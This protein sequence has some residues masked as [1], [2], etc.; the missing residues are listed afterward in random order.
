MRKLLALCVIT[1]MMIAVSTAQARIYSIKPT[2]SFIKGIL[3]IHKYEG[4]WKDDGAPY[5]GGVQM[6]WDF[7]LTYGLKAVQA[8]GTANHWPIW[9]QI[10][11]AY[12]GYLARG[13]NPWPQTAR[14]CNLI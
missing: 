9:T 6:N 8:Y 14:K 11:V 10:R 5:W 1:V 7:Q 12:R 4:S 3:C 13:W 2:K